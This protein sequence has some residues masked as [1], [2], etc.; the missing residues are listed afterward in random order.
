MEDEKDFGRSKLGDVYLI[1]VL[2]SLGIMHVIVFAT[3]I[4]CDVIILLPAH[5]K[6]AVDMTGKLINVLSGG[7]EDY[8]AFF[9]AFLIAT[10]ATLVVVWV[11]SKIL[12]YRKNRRQPNDYTLTQGQ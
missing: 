2:K 1:K 11:I 12:S 5:I 6:W 4:L 8:K 10:L 3:M 7:N 9:W